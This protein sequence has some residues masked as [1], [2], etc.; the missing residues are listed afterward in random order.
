MLK[1]KSNKTLTKK[2]ASSVSIFPGYYKRGDDLCCCLGRALDEKL[3]PY[4]A[5][6]LHAEQMRECAA[7][8][9]QIY[10]VLKSNPEAQIDICADTHMISLA[11]P[12]KIMQ[13]L[14]DQGLAE[15]DAWESEGDD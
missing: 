7:H 10:D 9:Q 8:L 15:Y 11:A 14:V 13:V 12:H 2:S 3:K 1:T 6:R 5:F 4:E